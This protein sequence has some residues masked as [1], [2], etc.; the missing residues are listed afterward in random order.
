[1]LQKGVDSGLL[2]LNLRG[3]ITSFLTGG[4]AV[5]QGLNFLA[6]QQKPGASQ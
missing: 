6:R 1:L 4:N 2:K 3:H 5:E